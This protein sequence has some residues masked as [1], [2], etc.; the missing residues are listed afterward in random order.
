M[1][2]FQL[3]ESEA[4]TVDI[5]ATN[6]ELKDTLKNLAI[7]AIAADKTLTV[8]NTERSALLLAAGE[9]MIAKSGW[10]NIAQGANWFCRSPN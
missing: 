2:T 10:F 7:A 4:L 5:K 8:N 9:G 1:S 6:P 3:S